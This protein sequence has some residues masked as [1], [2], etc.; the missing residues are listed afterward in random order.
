MMMIIMIIMI[1]II[2]ESPASATAPTSQAML[3][4]TF[5]MQKEEKEMLTQHPL[6]PGT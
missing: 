4:L 6:H 2:V 3:N 1:S 5:E